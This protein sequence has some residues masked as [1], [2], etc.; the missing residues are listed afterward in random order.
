MSCRA[1]RA[2][3]HH[4]PASLL[5]LLWPAP[6]RLCLTSATTSFGPPLLSNRRGPACE[7]LRLRR[8]SAANSAKS[9]TGQITTALGRRLHVVTGHRCRLLL[10]LAS[11]P[12]S[13]H[14]DP[15][16]S[17]AKPP[18]SGLTPAAEQSHQG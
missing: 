12:L 2:H 14:L 13:I 17:V 6:R 15:A 7:S 8:E 5:L 16:S 10:R 1:K 4:E 9:Y 11:V 18:A 3:H